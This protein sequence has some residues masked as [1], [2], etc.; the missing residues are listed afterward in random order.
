MNYSSKASPNSAKDELLAQH[1]ACC[2]NSPIHRSRVRLWAQLSSAECE[3]LDLRA[4]SETPRFWK[5]RRLQGKLPK[6]TQNLSGQKQQRF[7][8]RDRAQRARLRERLRRVALRDI[9]QRA[10]I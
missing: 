2:W 9:L 5:A 3:K 7:G 10:R 8:A 1:I 6:L 4:T